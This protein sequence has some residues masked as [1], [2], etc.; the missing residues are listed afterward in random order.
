M[1]RQLRAS[2]APTRQSQGSVVARVIRCLGLAGWRRHCHCPLL[3][4]PAPQA[5]DPP[6]I[7]FVRPRPIQDSL[8]GRALGLVRPKLMFSR[9]CGRCDG[10]SAGLQRKCVVCWCGWCSRQAM[11]GA[12]LAACLRAATTQ[13]FGDGRH[14]AFDWFRIYGVGVA[15]SSHRADFALALLLRCGAPS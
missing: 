13:H 8:L 11:R 14:C 6:F 10:Q 7:P 5:G 15:G 3:Q 9:V 2:A 1:G 12:R 4:E